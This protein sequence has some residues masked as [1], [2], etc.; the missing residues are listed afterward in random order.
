M[1]LGQ[2]ALAD[3]LPVRRDFAFLLDSGVAAG[4]VV[5]AA[6]AADKAL[7]V[8]VSVFDVFEGGAIPTGKKSLAIE[9]TLQ[10]KERTLTDSE[11]EAVAGKIV[12]EVRKAAG[13]EIRG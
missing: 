4:D 8:G 12:A 3:L 2:A 9:V 1:A 10:P 11:I 7:I 5:K 13:G 6:L